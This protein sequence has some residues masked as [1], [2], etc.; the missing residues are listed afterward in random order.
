MDNAEENFKIDFANLEL[1]NK[2]DPSPHACADKSYD[3]IIT[4]LQSLHN[5]HF[6]VKETRF[7]RDRHSVQPWMTD[8]LLHLIKSKDKFYVRHRKAKPNSPEKALLKHHLK[9]LTQRINQSIIEAKQSY[10]DRE[11]T[12]NNNDMKSTWRTINEMLN[13]KRSKTKYPP[14]FTP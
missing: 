6:P 3:T 13:K 7:R 14:F 12:K 4:H 2:I 5:K 1:T 10:Y 11:I 8:D 9:S